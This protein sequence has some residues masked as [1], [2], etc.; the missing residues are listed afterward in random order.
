MMSKTMISNASAIA[1]AVGLAL[2]A[3][4]LAQANTADLP[5]Y[6]SQ[7]MTEQERLEYR[8]QMREAQTPEERKQLRSEHVERMQQRARD[9]AVTLPD[10]RPGA[11]AGMRTPPGDAER[12]GRMMPDGRMQPRDGHGQG[13]GMEERYREE[14]QEQ[15]RENMMDNEEHRRGSGSGM[16]GGG[17]N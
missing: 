15:R 1:L 14:H 17:R 6:G 7:L 5:V 4:S 12:D 11:G 16:G 10:D 9:Q 2:P 13:R 8:E 3:I